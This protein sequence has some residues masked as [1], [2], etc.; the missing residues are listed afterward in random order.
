MVESL[1]QI[2]AL[3]RVHLDQTRLGS[4]HRPGGVCLAVE[5]GL[6]ICAVIHDAISLEAPLDRLE[7]DAEKLVGCIPPGIARGVERV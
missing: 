4:A 2:C 3:E 1:S 6:Q 7:A 5:A